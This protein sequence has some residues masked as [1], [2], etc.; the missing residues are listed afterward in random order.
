MLE[1]LLLGVE[2]LGGLT[3]PTKKEGG[4]SAEDSGVS[5]YINNQRTTSF[6]KNRPTHSVV[7]RRYMFFNHVTTNEDLY[8]DT[9]FYYMC[10]FDSE[11][12]C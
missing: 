10:S 8:L 1:N 4:K 7:G 3:S 6:L 12:A 5:V 11:R 2:L 9:H